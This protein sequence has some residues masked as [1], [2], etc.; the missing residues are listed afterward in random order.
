MDHAAFIPTPASTKKSTTKLQLNSGARDSRA[1][2]GNQMR[3]ERTKP[4]PASGS[5]FDLAPLVVEVTI[6]PRFARR[7]QILAAQEG[8]TVDAVAARLLACALIP[9][10]EERR[11]LVELDLRDARV[12][13]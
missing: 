9:D 7:L 10:P 13:S 4:T 2:G 8:R 3:E 5:E 6:L 12:Q 11:R 1:F